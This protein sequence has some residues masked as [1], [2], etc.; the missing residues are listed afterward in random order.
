MTWNLNL[1]YSTATTSWLYSD[2][3]SEGI[4]LCFHNL[5]FFGINIQPLSLGSQGFFF[6]FYQAP[7]QTA[8]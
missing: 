2:W 1:A 5:W 8:M 6:A 4:A 7:A 3:Q